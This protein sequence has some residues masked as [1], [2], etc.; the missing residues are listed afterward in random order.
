M[1]GSLIWISACV[2]PGFS[3]PE[4][5]TTRLDEPRYSILK[6]VEISGRIASRSLSRSASE[7]RA[8]CAGMPPGVSVSIK[9]QPELCISRLRRAAKILSFTV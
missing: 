4:P 9:I 1:A 3:S 8:H 6:Q 7:S 5:L 2:G